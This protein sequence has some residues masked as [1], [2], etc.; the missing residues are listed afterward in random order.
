MK[1]ATFIPRRRSRRGPVVG[2]VFGARADHH[3]HGDRPGRRRIGRRHSRCD[4]GPHQR[5]ARARS[6]PRSSPTRRA[7]TSSRTSRP[8]V[9]T[10]EV[11]I[12]GFQT[13]QA[14]AGITVS[15]GDRVGVE[16][17]DARTGR[18]STKP[19]PSRAKARSFRRR[20]A[21]GRS[22]LDRRRSRTCRCAPRRTSR[23]WSPSCP[24]VIA[25]GASAGGTRLGGVGQNN[26]M[27]DGI[28]AMDTGNN[29]QMLQHEHR[30]D[31]RGQGPDAGLPGGVRPVERAADHGRHQ[32]RHQ[33][34]PRV[35][36]RH[37]DQL[38]LEREQLGQRR[39][40]ATPS[41]DSK[42][43]HLRLLHRRS[44][45]Q[46]RAGDNK[47]FFFYAHEFRPTDRRDQRRQPHP[48]SRADRSSSAPATS[49]R[50][51][52]TTA[53]CS[54]AF[55]RLHDG[56]AVPEQQDSGEP[57]VCHR[58]R[59][60]QPLPAA[61]RGRRRRGRTTTTRSMRPPFEQLTQQP[62]IRA[63]LPAVVEAAVHRQVLR[64]SGSGRRRRPGSSRAS[65][66]SSRRIPYITNYGV[67][68]QLRDQPDD[69]HRGHLRVHPE[70]AGGRQRRRRPRQRGGEPPEPSLGRTS[71][72][73]IRTPV[74]ST[75]GTTR[76]E[77]LKRRK[78]RRSGTAR[79]STCRRSSAGA[80]ASAPR[81]RTSGIPAG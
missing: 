45:G 42:Q 41:R 65:R 56:A 53:T 76:Y 20:A 22:R 21:S 12:D 70:R 37:Q 19:S 4:R 43:R 71:R 52:T 5:I 75:S 36:L 25:G 11:T 81:R 50:P 10:I 68:R 47:L 1:R 62:A 24:G 55:V 18:R 35:G 61:E 57:A 54:P 69:V 63:R 9:Y 77:V 30:V 51:A 32:E 16:R 34:L 8:T 80:A 46:A 7:T 60:A 39:R 58:R 66:T 2:A 74:W 3:R 6:A 17:A 79:R 64:R 23:A 15:G 31:R 28:S 72:C 26:I 13:V 59:D 44:G 38:G 33:P 73:S 14:Q 29:G 27:M 40:T 78:A 49:R 48:A 67:H